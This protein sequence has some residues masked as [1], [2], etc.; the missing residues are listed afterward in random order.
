M[1]ENSTQHAVRAGAVES[2]YERRR[3]VFL[4]RDGVINENRHDYVKTWEE[5]VFLPGIMEPLGLLAHSDFL[6]IIVSNQSAIHRGL[7]SSAMVDEINHRMV[8]QVIKAGA[9]IDGVYFCPH[10]PGE[11]CDCRKPQPGLLLRAAEEMQIDLEQSY[12]VGDKLVDVAAGRAAGCRSMLVLTGEGSKQDLT[13]IKDLVVVRDL[14]EAVELILHDRFDALKNIE[15]Q[16]I[17]NDLDDAAA[18]I[19]DVDD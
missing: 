5:F 8:N 3:A 4:D 2:G 11:A 16:S 12:C 1:K 15:R 10:M 17:Q 13:A 14:Q 7:V 9:R 6:V 18:Q 19:E